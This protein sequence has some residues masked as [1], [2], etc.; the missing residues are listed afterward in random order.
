MIL[1]GNMEMLVFQNYFR[2]DFWKCKKLE[3]KKKK[4][5]KIKHRLSQQLQTTW[6][7]SK[8]P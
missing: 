8:I 7:A 6:C 5:T 1:H 4:K 2:K 3:Y